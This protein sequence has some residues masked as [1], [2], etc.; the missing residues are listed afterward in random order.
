MRPT[1]SPNAASAA[2]C[3][4]PCASR[5]PG[6]AHFFQHPPRRPTASAA[7]G[8]KSPDRAR[9]TA[10]ERRN[11][12]GPSNDNNDIEHLLQY[13][14]CL[15]LLFNRDIFLTEGFQA[16]NR[17]PEVPPGPLKGPG[18]GGTP[19][20]GQFTA[21]CR[22][23]REISL[24]SSGAVR[25]ARL[26]PTARSRERDLRAGAEVGAAR[27]FAPSVEIDPDG[28]ATGPQVGRAC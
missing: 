3:P 6:R 22:R 16:K 24:A 4:E 8:V 1:R 12:R 10:A 23:A 25:V 27:D 20:G 28:S 9:A 2:S 11:G 17:L 5:R 19:D 21:R 18:R 26:P 15:L 14:Q 7:P 13:T